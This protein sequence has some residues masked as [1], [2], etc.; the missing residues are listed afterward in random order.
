MKSLAFAFLALVFSVTSASA[1]TYTW[2]NAK[3][4]PWSDSTA[5]S[6]GVAPTSN[7]DNVINFT[8]ISQNSTGTLTTAD[9]QLNQLTASGT[10]STKTLAISS[11]GGGYLEF[12]ANSSAVNP[13]LTL[14]RTN[15][16]GGATNITVPMTITNTLTINSTGNSTTISGAI[17]NNSGIVAEGTGGFALSSV[18]SGAG[19]LT[20]SMTNATVSTGTNSTYTGVTTLSGGTL[21]V[22]LL[23]NGGSNSS[24]GKS[25]NA[26]ANL[27]L[28]GGS[29]AFVGAGTVST[30][31]LFTLTQ[32]GGTL[33]SSGTSGAAENFTSAGSVAFS[34]SGARTL[35][36]TGTSTGVSNLAPILG[37]GTGGGT[38]VA[39]TGVG[40]WEL[41]GANT[42]TGGTTV[43]GG[44]LIVN[45]S[46]ALG[47]SSGSIGVSGGTL[48][49][50]GNIISSGQLTFGT[51]TG[52]IANSLGGSSSLST[53]GV[54]VNGTGVVNSGV[55]LGGDAVVNGGGVFTVNGAATGAVSINSNGSLGGTGTTG[56][57]TLASGGAIN[58]ADGQ[59]GTLTIGGLTTT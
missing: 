27:V 22:K 41:S 11:S 48:D 35:T 37:D 42:Y 36:L 34:G 23:A 21:S 13:M 4:A 17:T 47:S 25:T 32:N 1:A 31:R 6:G 53:S 9:F 38:S 40:T 8:G 55:S 49:I 14:S 52:T 56:A 26:A 12:I 50:K 29:L 33:D 3:I 24:I 30:D 5:W 57:V 20:I 10:N 51:G 44:T 43:T 45:S 2:I 28:D 59:I 46:T 15:S 39:K 58:M 54:A 7:Q 18:I 16:G 19:N